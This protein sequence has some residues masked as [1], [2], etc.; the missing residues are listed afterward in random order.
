MKQIAIFAVCVL[1][2]ESS[3]KVMGVRN[4]LSPPGRRLEI[5]TSSGSVLTPLHREQR[6]LFVTNAPRS[7]VQ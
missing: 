6:D 1:L 7:N 5:R 3:D 2:G 4:E